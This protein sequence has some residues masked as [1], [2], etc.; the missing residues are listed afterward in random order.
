MTATNASGTD[1]HSVEIIVLGKPS[2][3]LGPL[4]V[5]NV[6]EDRADLEW[7][8]PED[9]G[10]APIDHYEIEKMDMATGRWVPCGRSET[11]KCTVQNLQPGHEYKFRVRAVN[12]EGES[13][14]LT[15][16]TA[17]L[18]KN[19]YEV[20]GKLEKPELV[21]WDKD[22]VDLAWKPPADD[23]GAPVEAYVIE[24]K[25]KN[26]R[27]EEALVVPGDQITA[28]VPSLKEGEEYQFRISARN[29]AG[30]GDPSD[31]SD[32]VVAKPR[33]LAPHIHR[34][35]LSDTVIKVGASLKFTVHIDGEPAPDVTWSFNGKGIGESKA[36]IDNE[37]YISKFALA[38]AVRKQSGKYTIT[39]TNANGTDSVT[40]NIKVKSKP[41]KP[42][43]PIDVTDVFED[44]ATL[45]W[46]PPEDDGGEPIEFYE[47]E[48]MNTKD[49]LWVPCGR[50][51]DTH[52]TVDSLNKGDHYKFRVKAVNSEG[53]SDPLET[54][55]DILAKNPFDRPDRPG[56]P[57][58]TD[59]DSDHV[60]LKW[61]P[62]LSDGGAPIE[63][64]QIEKRTKYGR[65]VLN[66]IVLKH[67]SVFRW[68]P[69]ITVPGGQTKATVP[70]LT[71][72]EE[73]EFRVIAVNKGGPS[74]PSDA[75]K[76]VIAK[77]RNCQ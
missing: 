66:A 12:K 18:A 14:P 38:K 63:E 45:D 21:D 25:D 68:E 23:G 31:P 64:Y 5:S 50:S 44:R 40:I 47:I 1:K 49:G 34:E 42:R 41:T 30:T 19:P 54:D 57:E 53:A 61:D 69:A 72:N 59:W 60:D 35:D 36:Q 8:V 74:D 73:Y 28:T 33:N 6:Y 52:F 3:P 77:P 2:T 51:G 13:D 58:P 24:K 27:W 76:A 46:K 4:E 70:D 37:P 56:R 22:H 17:I 62:P 75:S 26:G 55:T 43:G 65:Q 71:A 10:G 15:T 32:R 39:A 11:T 67:C 16:N 29:K 7:K 9:D 20:P 48:K